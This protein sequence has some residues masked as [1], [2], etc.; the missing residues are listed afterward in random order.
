MGKNYYT[1]L[2]ENVEALITQEEFDKAKELILEEFKMPYIPLDVEEQLQRYLQ[3]ISA[4]EEE[5]SPTGR[6]IS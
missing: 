6:R 4:E 5:V 2:L 1:E 3:T